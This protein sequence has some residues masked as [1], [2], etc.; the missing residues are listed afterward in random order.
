MN[1]NILYKIALILFLLINN[2]EKDYI[3]SSIKNNYK[4]KTNSSIV[5]I[6]IM[7]H[8]DFD[9]EI[10]NPIYNI[11]ADDKK[12]LKKN[13]N[14]DILYASQSTLYNKKRA[15]SEMSKLYF[16]YELYKNATISSKYIGL[17]HYRRYFDFCNNIPNLDNIFENHDVILS[18][19]IKMNLN[20]RDH[21]C[22]NHI[23]QNFD[24]IIDIIK[25][26]KPEYYKTAIK[27]SKEKQNYYF[28]LFIMKKY[29]FYNYCKFMYDILFEFDKRHNFSSD[30]DILNYSCKYFNNR[31]E[32][33]YQSRVESFLSERIS[34]IFFKQYFKK[35]KHCGVK[36]Y[37]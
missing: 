34:N 25:E 20:T 3:R 1:Q 36:Y 23:F 18:R 8:K 12:Q 30:E 9:C 13:Y 24:E 32:Y 28:N 26:I 19:K 31:E 7:T 4:T 22:K 11:V 35:I 14:L 16:I 37:S 17:N 21:Y 15:Y 33:Y 5:K 10:Y 6:F 27:A 29:D 2:F